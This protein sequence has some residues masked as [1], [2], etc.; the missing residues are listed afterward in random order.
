MIFSPAEIR[1]LNSILERTHLVYLGS[2]LGTDVLSPSEIKTLKL[3][4]IDVRHLPNI[5][6]V[7]VAFR[8]GLLAHSLGKAKAT[9]MSFNELKNFITS[10]D[11]V[12]L[13][14]VEQ[15]ALRTIK[16]RAYSDIKGLE[17]RVIKGVGETIIQKSK[18]QRQRYE[19]VIKEEAAKSIRNNRTVAQMASEIGHRTQDWARDLDRIADYVLHEAFDTG[20]AFSVQR[21]HGEDAEVYKEVYPGACKHCQRLYLTNGIGSKPIVFK[22]S[23]LVSNGSN[24]GRKVDEWKAVIGPTHPWCR[25]ELENVPPGYQW[26]DQK[27]DFRPKRIVKIQRK[28]RVKVTVTRL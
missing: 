14:E 5:G 11:F 15:F 6:K 23:T 17:T 3:N 8:F 28:S 2:Q 26:D 12:P 7:D 9:N 25:C 4:G 20:K 27:K 22:L 24:V 10:G 21:Q 19:K 18:T 13:S 16:H 1:A